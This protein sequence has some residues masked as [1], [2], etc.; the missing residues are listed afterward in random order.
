VIFGIGL[1]W[2]GYANAAEQ[3]LLDARMAAWR[4]SADEVGATY[5]L[6]PVWRD[7]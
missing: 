1:S 2:W 5:D 7:V 4:V 3:S 6:F